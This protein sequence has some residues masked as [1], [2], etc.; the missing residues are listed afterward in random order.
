MQENNRASVCLRTRVIKIKICLFPPHH[1][2]K[3]NNV[4]F[5]SC[6]PSLV[7]LPHFLF[8]GHH[9][10]TSSSCSMGIMPLLP[11]PT[12]AGEKSSG[13]IRASWS[14]NKGEAM[15][16]YPSRTL[17]NSIFDI[18]IFIY[19][20]CQPINP[21]LDGGDEWIVS[22]QPTTPPQIQFQC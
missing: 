14:S 2:Q 10:L 18:H 4:K 13:K 22:T 15:Q 3:Q 6:E 7:N 8:N 11:T 21:Y 9:E 16:L 19:T 20:L 12:Y 1:H 17:K 5:T